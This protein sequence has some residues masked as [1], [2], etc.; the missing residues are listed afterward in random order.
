[1]GVMIIEEQ[2]AV[3]VVNMRCRIVTNGDFMEFSVVRGG[4]AAVPKL[5][6]EDFFLF[7]ML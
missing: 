4:D 2:R 1:M 5:L 3:L 6:W 7:R